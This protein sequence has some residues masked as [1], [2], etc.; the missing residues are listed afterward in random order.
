MY[1]VFSSQLAHAYVKYGSKRD[2]FKQLPT[3]KKKAKRGNKEAA[4]LT[5]AEKGEIVAIV[6]CCN[7]AGPYIPPLVISKGI[8]QRPEFTDNLPNG[9]VV[10]MSESGYIN[11]EY[12]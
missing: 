3:K 7:A 4:I 5:S 8:R 12:F 6:A 9:S 2:T 11:E 10:A 1:R